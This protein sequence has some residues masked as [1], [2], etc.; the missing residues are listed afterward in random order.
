MMPHFDLP[1]LRAYAEDLKVVFERSGKSWAIELPSF[2][3]AY[4]QGKARDE[5]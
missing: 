3:G 1:R 5:A 4:T 2:P